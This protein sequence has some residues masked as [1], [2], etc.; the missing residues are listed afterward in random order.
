MSGSKSGGRPPGPGAFSLGTP[1]GSSLGKRPVSPRLGDVRPAVAVRA[2]P[3]G[4]DGWPRETC[5]H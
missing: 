5:G 2:G 1:L 4:T 3:S